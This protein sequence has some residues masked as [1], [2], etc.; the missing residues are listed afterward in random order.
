MLKYLR[1]QLATM[2]E[3]RT[4]L[5]AALDAI[6]VDPEKEGRGLKP[7][8]EAAFAEARKAVKEKDDAILEM[9]ARVKE[10]EED[11]RREELVQR[12]RDAHGAP[13]EER[14]D[15]TGGGT[16]V[17]R[18]QTTYDQFGDQ[19]YF[20][21]LVTVGLNRTGAEEAE[22][23]LAQA[24]KECRI[25]ARDKVR[26]EGRANVLREVR[27]LTTTDGAGGDFVPPLWMVEEYITLARAA[28][29]T[30][31]RVRNMSLPKGTDSLN[32]PRIATGTAVAEQATQ[33]TAVQNTDATTNAVSATVTTIAG[34]QVVAVQ[35][36]EQS[37]INMDEILLADLALDYAAKVDLFVLNNNAAGKLGLLNVAGVNTATRTGATT[38]AQFYSSFA[39]LTQQIY[40]TRF[41]A[42]DTIVMHPR[43]WASFMAGA[44]SSG[45]PFI[46]PNSSQGAYNALG[47]SN[48]LAAQGVVG[49]IAG[50]PVI[51]DPNIPTNLGVGTNEDRIIVFR[52]QDSILWE[53]APNAEAFRETKAD[54][55]SVLL[56][57]YRYAAFTGSRY[58]KSIGVLSGTGLVP[59][60][61]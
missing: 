11:E 44:D 34:Q 19:S 1:K 17:L 56:R 58:P 13:V 7:E 49:E 3:E 26:R 10:A 59:P 20:R 8:E 45:R 43:R 12:S 37:P 2:H 53:G 25:D 23:R 39:D 18:E 29:P 6:L 33:N 21:D 41:L 52:S 5:K 32:I 46:V 38:L 31:D 42:P 15:D 51:A 24:D 4:G 54:Q 55:L 30:A 36:I 14:K 48:G 28:R 47:V 16:I 22:R 57:F 9:E 61:F 50:L 40:G 35:L 27:A 60:T